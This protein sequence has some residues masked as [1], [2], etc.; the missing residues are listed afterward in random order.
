MAKGSKAAPVAK[1][2]M[3]KAQLMTALSERCEI[4]KKQAA[5]IYDALLAIAAE[6]AKNPSGFVFPGLG[7]LIK[8]E[9]AA[10]MGR[11]PAT[12]EII[13]IP[14]KTAVCFRISKICKDAVLS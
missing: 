8:V 14:P 6:E 7:K 13:Q 12:N 11:N 9:R 10:R 4:T 2:P 5:D 1:K 3:T